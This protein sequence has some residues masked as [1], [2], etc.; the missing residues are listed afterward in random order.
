M[1]LRC[2]HTSK[3][4]FI[5][6]KS[7]GT[8]SQ[9]GFFLLCSNL[10]P[11]YA[12]DCGFQVEVDEAFAGA[13]DASLR[14]QAEGARRMALVCRP[15]PSFGSTSTRETSV[16]RNSCIGWHDLQRRSCFYPRPKAWE[17][18][19]TRFGLQRARRIPSLFSHRVQKTESVF[20]RRPARLSSPWLNPGAFRRDVVSIPSAIHSGLVL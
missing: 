1:R 9:A 17:A 6:T 20:R 8:S 15:T 18:V 3:Q 14:L 11:Q 13:R 19:Q 4:H 10:R 5:H 12:A 16:I 7:R 2:K